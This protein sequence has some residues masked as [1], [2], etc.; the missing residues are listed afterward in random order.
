[1]SAGFGQAPIKEEGAAMP[2]D[3]ECHSTEP[4]VPT[5]WFERSFTALE[6]AELAAILHASGSPLARDVSQ[7]MVE[8]AKE[9]S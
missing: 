4:R 2:F 8:C 7:H 6:Y 5:A 1:M 3:P 9:V